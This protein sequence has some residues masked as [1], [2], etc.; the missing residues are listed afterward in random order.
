[1]LETDHTP[2]PLSS[3]SGQA[4]TQSS[5]TPTHQD[6][7]AEAAAILIRALREVDALVEQTLTAR[8]ASEETHTAVAVTLAR[9]V[10]SLSYAGL[11]ANGVRPW[12]ARSL[13]SDELRTVDLTLSSNGLPARD[14]KRFSFWTALHQDSR[15]IGDAETFALAL[16]ASPMRGFAVSIG[17]EEVLTIAKQ[18][19]LPLDADSVGLL[20]TYAILR[21]SIRADNASLHHIATL[22]ERL[23]TSPAHHAQESAQPPAG[24]PPSEAAGAAQKSAWA[25]YQPGGNSTP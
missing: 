16:S 18:A 6:V 10:T 12:D 1:M 20:T 4:P 14:F 13:V 17:R 24:A 3:P 25:S 7:T 21:A 2:D 8:G 23:R 11:I 22:C 9:V 15:D 5:G 19:N